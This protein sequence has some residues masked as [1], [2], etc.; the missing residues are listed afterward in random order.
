[1][2]LSDSHLAD[3]FTAEEKS[4]DAHELRTKGEL[5]GKKSPSWLTL[6]SEMKINIDF[7]RVAFVTKIN[8]EWYFVVMEL[9]QQR[10]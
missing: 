9:F 6:Y 4:D 2:A 5:I 7:S 8:G 10:Y 3:Q 1:M